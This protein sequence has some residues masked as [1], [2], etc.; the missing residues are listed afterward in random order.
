MQEKKHTQSVGICIIGGLIHSVKAN[1][2]GERMAFVIHDEPVAIPKDTKVVLI[3]RF[4]PLS[5]T[6]EQKVEQNRIMGMNFDKMPIEVL[7]TIKVHSAAYGFSGD[8]CADVAMEYAQYT[9]PD[10]RFN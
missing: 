2:L 5:L 3:N 1:D 10:P 8:L 4:S 9:L 7:E 6:D